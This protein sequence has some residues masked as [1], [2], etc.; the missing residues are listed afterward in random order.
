MPRWPGFRNQR[1]VTSDRWLLVKHC[2][3]M[4]LA[5][6]GYDGVVE[7]ARAVGL[8]QDRIEPGSPV[9]GGS[10][11]GA[12]SGET[13]DRQVAPESLDELHDDD[14]VHVGENQVDDDQVDMVVAADQGE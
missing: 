6:R 5:K 10:Q 7:L 14:T 3:G 9:A 13:E 11:I 1:L 12:F 8:E 4:G 2:S